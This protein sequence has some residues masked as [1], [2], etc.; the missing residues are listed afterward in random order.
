[1]QQRLLTQVRQGRARGRRPGTSRPGM[2]QRWLAHCVCVIPVVVIVVLAVLVSMP[3]DG[4]EAG[5]PKD[6]DNTR[7]VAPSLDGGIA[8]LN[9]EGP[10]SLEDLKGRIVLL[11]FWTL[12]CINCIHT[13]P[14]LAK[15]EAKY[16]G[17]LVVIGVHSPKF[18]NE[19]KTAS[20]RKAILRYRVNHPV[21]NDADMLIW[22][23]YGVNSW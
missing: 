23:R 9:A 3:H 14:D 2:I 16:P 6:K 19:K 8:W 12:C 13:I 7:V 21:V 4:I 11:D 22:R 1:M 5:Q 15:L 20:V 10:L 17:V 18:P